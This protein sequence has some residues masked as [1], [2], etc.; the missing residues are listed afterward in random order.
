MWSR[1]CVRVA[2]DLSIGSRCR[3]RFCIFFFFSS[4]RRHTRLQGDWSSDVS[5]SD[6]YYN[7][8]SVRATSTHYSTSLPRDSTPLPRG[9]APPMVAQPDPT[10]REAHAFGSEQR[11]L[12]GLAPSDRKSVV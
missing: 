3:T 9:A 11:A 6:L 1:T 12:D 5:S 7:D 10:A 2:S 8:W 4:R